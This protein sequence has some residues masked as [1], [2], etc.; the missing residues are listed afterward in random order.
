M[1]DAS[2]LTSVEQGVLAITLNRP[3][4]RNALTEAMLGELLDALQRAELDAAVRAVA[5]RAAGQDFCAGMDLHE[6][7]ASADRTVE[8]NRASALRLAE[9]LVRMRQVPKPIVA[10]V[11]GRA[12]GG[13]C[14]LA[15]GCDILLAGRSAQFGYPEVHRGF[16]PA[17]VLALLQRGV[18]QKVAFD[19]IATGRMLGASEALGHGLVS[20]VCD[21]SGLEAEAA[22][23]LHQLVASSATALALTKQLFYQIE[24]LSFEQGL[25]LGAAANAVS[26]TTPDFR[27]ALEAFLKP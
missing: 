9:I 15:T 10:V 4:K 14:G 3:A 24:G 19:L 5:L 8:E 25:Q 12:F 2:I 6:L 17:V 22:T 27:R 21:D 1:S 18:P 7:L 23:V 20:R 13:G 11:Q 16:V 26:R